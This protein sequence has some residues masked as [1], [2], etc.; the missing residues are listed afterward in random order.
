MAGKGPA[1]VNLSVN[2]TQGRR[3]Q[4]PTVKRGLPGTRELTCKQAIPTRPKGGEKP[5]SRADSTVTGSG[6]PQRWIQRPAALAAGPAPLA[7]PPALPGLFAGAPAPVSAATHRRRLR[8]MTAAASAWR[9]ER[10]R[11]RSADAV[12]AVPPVRGRSPARGSGAGESGCGGEEGG[13]GTPPPLLLLLP[14][15]RCPSAAPHAHGRDAPATAATAAVASPLPCGSVAG[16]QPG[17]T[18]ANVAGAP[19]R[20]GTSL[21]A[22]L[23]GGAAEKAAE[24]SGAARPSSGIAGSSSRLEVP[25]DAPVR[26]RRDCC[27]CN[28]SSGG[29]PAAVPTAVA[30]PPSP[31][32]PPAP[33]LLLASVRR[34]AAWTVRVASLSCRKWR[35]TSHERTFVWM[36]SASALQSCS[37]GWVRAADQLPVPPDTLHAPALPPRTSTPAHARQTASQTWGH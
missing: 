30:S 12:A 34:I 18:T 23:A 28:G 1:V 33:P 32:T 20:G 16:G 4:P 35:R 19:T 29:G 31:G 2:Y 15:L 25:S 3:S 14:P 21:T 11:L 22:A 9:R 7:S 6:N 17:W 37:S 27:G 26:E 24:A 36:R 13:P 10:C 8:A 5:G